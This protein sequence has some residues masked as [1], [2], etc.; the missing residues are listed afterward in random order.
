[1]A[2]DIILQHFHA[3]LIIA[4]LRNDD[5]EHIVMCFVVI[6]KKLHSLCMYTNT[7]YSN[8]KLFYVIFLFMV[9]R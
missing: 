9:Q 1:M 3:G 8:W 4:A 6:V 2:Q 7:F 5:K